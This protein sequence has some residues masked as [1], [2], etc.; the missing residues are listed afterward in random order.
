MSPEE[1]HSDLALGYC[2]P[3]L[4]QTWLPD[5]HFPWQLLEPNLPSRAGGS[6]CPC[7]HLQHPSSDLQRAQH[8]RLTGRRAFPPHKKSWKQSHCGTGYSFLADQRPG[9][10]QPLCQPVYFVFVFVNLFLGMLIRFSIERCGYLYYF[11]KTPENIINFFLLL[12]AMLF[13]VINLNL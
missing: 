6:A 9:V 12:P 2:L 7:G 3:L 11:P 8:G 10:L 13:K 5:I 1:K 4:A